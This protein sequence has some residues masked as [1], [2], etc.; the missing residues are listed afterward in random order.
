VVSLRKEFV[1]TDEGDVVNFL[2]IKFERQ[3]NGSINPTQLGLINKG[4]LL[5]KDPEGEERTR[6]FYYR[7][8]VGMIIYLT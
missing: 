3:T 4:P 7:A 1:P 6:E 8:A 5:T 2:G